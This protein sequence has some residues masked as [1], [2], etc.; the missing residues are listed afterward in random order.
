[1]MQTVTTIAEVRNWSAAARRTGQTVGLVPTMGALHEG[2]RSLIRR[3]RQACQA[4]AVSLFVNPTQFGPNEDFDAYPRDLTADQGA[5]A[6]EGV[7]LIFAP[8]AAEMYPT[9]P[10]TTVHVAGLTERLCGAHR[11]GHFDGVTTVVAKL[12]NIVEPDAAYFGQKDAQQAI[13]VRRMVADLDFRCRIVICPTV[14][15]PDG[16]ATSSRNAYLTAEQRRRA[17]G[18]GEALRRAES[19]VREGRRDAREIAEA[20]RRHLAA[21]GIQSIDYIEVV[22]AATLSPVE[23]IDG[24]TLIALAVRIGRTRLIDNTIVLDDGAG[25]RETSSR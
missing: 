21:K 2:H 15:D 11:P 8:S 12:L 17:L 25:L 9:P 23:R 7:D 13:V 4:V 16:L 1:M 22:D 20:I 14:Y 5:C 6:A 18:L 24:P 19:R 3:A 10:T